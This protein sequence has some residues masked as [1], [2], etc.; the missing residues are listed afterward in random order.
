GYT[1]HLV[2]GVWLGK[3]DGTPTKKLTGGSLPVEIWNRVMKASH[4]GVPMANLPGVSQSPF[5][6]ILPPWNIFAP[7]SQKPERKPE[8]KPEP[9]ADKLDSW[10]IDRLFGRH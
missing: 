8:P 9:A 7:S 4:Q 5:A 3:D 10:L 6:G 2:T 1:A